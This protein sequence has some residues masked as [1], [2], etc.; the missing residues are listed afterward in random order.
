MMKILSE[1]QLR[2]AIFHGF[3]GSVEQANRAIKSGY[4][5]SFGPRS[6]RSAKSIK[7]L[8]ATPLNHLFAESDESKERIEDIYSAIAT[9]KG[10][11]V[12]ELQN[13]IENNY[14]KIFTYNYE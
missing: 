3:I 13:V 6:L 12:E 9:I 10:I 4:F 7:A 14:N 11:S 1:Y 8:T 2:A 5:L